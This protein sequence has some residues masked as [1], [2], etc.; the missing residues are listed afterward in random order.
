MRSDMMGT[1][2]RRYR[3]AVTIFAAAVAGSASAQQFGGGMMPNQQGMA[4]AIQ[5]ATGGNMMGMGGMQ[6]AGGMQGMGMGGGLQGMNSAQMQQLMMMRAM[7]GG[8]RHHGVQ[9]GFPMIFDAGPPMLPGSGD[10]EY[11]DD[12]QQDT[13]SKH[14]AGVEHRATLRAAREQQ[15]QLARERAAQAKASRPKAVAPK[16]GAVAGKAKPDAVAP[17]PRPARQMNGQ[18]F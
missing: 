1:P 4:Q 18:P 16:G 12:Q 6:G 14:S 7:S 3:L 11:A 10:E 15:K 5:N 13:S 17:E 8:G 9:S 2:R